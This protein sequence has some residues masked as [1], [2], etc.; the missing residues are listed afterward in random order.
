MPADLLVIV[1][2]RG[3][4]KRLP[5]K[6]LRLLGGRSLIAW[7]AEFLGR[8]GVLKDSIL[9][10]DSDAIAAEGRRVGL[11][12]PFLRPLE[13]AADSTSTIDVVF[14]ALQA[15][16]HIGLVPGS[17]VVVAQPTSPFRR[18]GLLR[19]AVSLMKQQP[20]T[21]SIVAMRRLHVHSSFVFGLSGEGRAAPIHG[22]PSVP[23]LEPTGSLYVTRLSALLEQK[24]LY[25]SPIAPL[26]VSAIEAVDIDTAEDLRI[27]NA[28][29][30]LFA[31]SQD[32]TSR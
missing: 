29:L 19:E 5:G 21:N 2:A 6:N 32:M 1:P 11:S 28:L 24:S 15:I 3:N 30:P 12:V 22:G 23:A 4:S 26:E 31:V 7:T 17:L 8:E 20:Q 25:A 9:S 14:H 10:T 16:H 18:C 27:A 13:F